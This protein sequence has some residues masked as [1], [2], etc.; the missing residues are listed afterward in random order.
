MG[1]RVQ[2]IREA[3]PTERRP[4]RVR[5]VLGV[6]VALAVLAPAAAWASHQFSDV[7]DANAFHD[8]IDAIGDAGI[9]A[10]FD[11]GTFKPG[12][13]VSRQ[14]MAAFMR[15]SAPR[16]AQSNVVLDSGVSVADGAT[17]IGD[18]RIQTPSSSATGLQF[19]TLTATVVVDQFAIPADC[20]TNSCTMTFE[21]VDTDTVCIPGCF[22][23]DFTSNPLV[24]NYGTSST[25][26][27]VITVT[28]VIR[29]PM[30][31][32]QAYS[33]RLTVST[34]GDVADTVFIDDIHLSATTSPFGWMGTTE[35]NHSSGNPLQT[36]PATREQKL[37]LEAASS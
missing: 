24:V 13:A 23:L 22:P 11:D 18:V 34:P 28:A 12:N 1:I 27:D 15:R 31:Q 33:L 25:V 4:R 10:G 17:N 8:D 6:V 16:V 32:D 21:W 3:G 9:A 26:D 29:E 5:R 14:A 30:G 37:D 2:I 20:S 36:G 7:S 35:L 19:V